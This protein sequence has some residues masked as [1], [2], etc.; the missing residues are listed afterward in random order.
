MKISINNLTINEVARIASKMGWV[1]VALTTDRG[2]AYLER[3]QVSKTAPAP[4]LLAVQGI[5]SI[6]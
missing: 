2:F 3:E 1:E 4:R 5:E 6:F